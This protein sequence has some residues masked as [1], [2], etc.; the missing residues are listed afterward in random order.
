MTD[1]EVAIKRL[2]RLKPGDV[3][4]WSWN[5]RELAAR[6]VQINAGTLYWCQSRI[7]VADE[8]LRL[9]DTYWNTVSDGLRVTPENAAEKMILKYEGNLKD[10]LAKADPHERA[11]Y[12]DIDCVDLSHPNSTRGNFYI[13][14]GAKRDVDKMRV[15]LKRMRADAKQRIE[16]AKRDVERY[17]AQMETLTADTELTWF[18]GELSLCDPYPGEEEGLDG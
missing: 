15:I 5:E 17:E 11:M 7:L 1:H 18:P 10:D 16:S 2:K 8:S 3:F 6:K 12:R 13:R 4:R 14:K 9:R